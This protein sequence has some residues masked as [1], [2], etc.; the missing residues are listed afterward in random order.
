MNIFPR[1]FACAERAANPRPTFET[2]ETSEFEAKWEEFVRKTPQYTRMLEDR[3]IKYKIPLP[4]VQNGEINT[5]VS[6]IQNVNYLL[7]MNFLNSI[8]SLSIIT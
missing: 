4:G 5:Q 7:I 3:G 8:Y 6:E 1:L 2:V